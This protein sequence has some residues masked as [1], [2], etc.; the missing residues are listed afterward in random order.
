ML[1]FFKRFA[2]YITLVLALSILDIAI[3]EYYGLRDARLDMACYMNIAAEYAM[4]T[5]QDNTEVISG[6]NGEQYNTK[7]YEAYLN[8]LKSNSTTTNEDYIS[9]AYQVLNTSYEDLKSKHNT[10]L[11]SNLEYKPLS[12]N[13]PYISISQVTYQYEYA[14]EKLLESNVSIK[15]T[16]IVLANYDNAELAQTIKDELQSVRDTAPTFSSTIN[17]VYVGLT[18]DGVNYAGAY[19]NSLV[20]MQLSVGRLDAS[21]QRKLYGNVDKFNDVLNS[22]QE[23]NQEKYKDIR[24][25]VSGNTVSE[26]TRLPKYS[27]QFNTKWYYVT[28]SG[29]LKV[30]SYK[31]T[32]DELNTNTKGNGLFWN[33]SENRT[34]KETI[35]SS[36]TDKRLYAYDSSLKNIIHP[37]LGSGSD[38]LGNGGDSDEDLNAGIGIP[39]G[40][41]MIA[42]TNGS[43]TFN[44]QKEY[45]IIG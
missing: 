20:T 43:S 40:Q 5:I 13:L 32:T 16:N 11:D 23:L 3:R 41:L 4:S 15:G 35:N 25:I 8:F 34:Y 7:E 33:S 28:Q 21:T 17:N 39:D 44:I 37:A 26:N 12:F 30:P 45:L 22:L 29:F 38:T 1:K 19:K 24:Y 9:I 14:L 31:Y 18:N 10:D 42:V 6:A 27:L 2:L 36:S